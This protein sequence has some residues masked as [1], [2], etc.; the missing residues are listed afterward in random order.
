M[1]IVGIVAG[2]DEEIAR[3]EKVKALLAEE[4]APAPK[5]RVRPPGIKSKRILSPEARAKIAAVQK[6][7]WAKAKRG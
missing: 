3:L 5:K 6:R 7:R 1:D 4:G 2:I